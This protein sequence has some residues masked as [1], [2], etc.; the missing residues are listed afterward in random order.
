LLV[1]LPVVAGAV[2]FLAVGVVVV[3][4]SRSAMLLRFLRSR[5]VALGGRVALAAVSLVSLP[6]CV[7]ALSSIAGRAP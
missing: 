3:L 1:V 2:V 4:L 6:G 7:S 5:S